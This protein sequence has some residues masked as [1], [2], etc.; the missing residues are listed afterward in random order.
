M[1]KYLLLLCLV[2]CI[3]CTPTAYK[4]PHIQITTAYG[5]IEVELFPEQAPKTVAAFLLFVDS[6][7][8]KNSSFYRVLTNENVP[9]EHNSGLVQ[10]GVYT[11]NP[12]LMAKLPGIIHEPTQQTHLSHTSGTISLARTTPGTASTEFFI[13]IG[14]QLQFDSGES[15]SGDGLGFAAFGK[16]VNGMEVVRK[17][18]NDPSRGESFNS[19]IKIA[20]IERL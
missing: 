17:I 13:C 5:E 15:A 2:F 14:D 18:Q 12:G 9:A 6:G 8:Y 1:N 4:N 3:S 20:N 16:V 7:Y 11:T 10:G 19:Q